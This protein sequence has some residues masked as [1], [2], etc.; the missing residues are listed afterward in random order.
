MR[1]LATSFVPL[2]FRST[3]ANLS[4]GYQRERPTLQETERQDITPF[5]SKPKELACS[6]APFP[7]KRLFLKSVLR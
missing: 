6:Q 1:A 5:Y 7:S 4:L 2:L 3:K